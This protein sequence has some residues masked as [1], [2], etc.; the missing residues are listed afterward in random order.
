RSDQ[1]QRCD[2]GNEHTLRSARS[3]GYHSRWLELGALS[4]VLRHG[5]RPAQLA[6]GD[7]RL[8]P[9][10]AQEDLSENRP[11]K[12]SARRSPARKMGEG[13]AKRFLGRQQRALV[14]SSP[15]SAATCAW[16][17]TSSLTSA[18]GVPVFS[19]IPH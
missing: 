2:L 6:R 15:Y 14:S 11:L 13:L 16:R 12:Q 7:R 3:G 5:I 19:S 1:H 17:C 9:V 4:D 8:H 18:A 10:A